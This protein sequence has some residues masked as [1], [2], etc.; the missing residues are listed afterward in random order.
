[1]F[2]VYLVVCL[3]V[4]L[5]IHCAYNRSTESFRR[6]SHSRS[7]NRLVGQ[8]GNSLDIVT[9]LHLWI[10]Q[11]ISAERD[12]WLLGTYSLNHSCKFTIALTTG[13]MWTLMVIPWTQI[14]FSLI[15]SYPIELFLFTLPGSP[16]VWL[17]SLQILFVWLWRDSW[18][19]PNLIWPVWFR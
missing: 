1:M 11:Q 12:I 5:W 18:S 3:C 16:F 9:L 15:P 7:D 8:I 17:S 6:I 4:C 14:T 10:S 19:V 13:R 2:C